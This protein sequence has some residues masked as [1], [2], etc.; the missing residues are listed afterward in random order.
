MIRDLSTIVL[1]TADDVFGGWKQA[2]AMYFSDGGLLD[3][4]YQ[5]K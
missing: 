2:Q 3:Q 4:I 5:V 1:F